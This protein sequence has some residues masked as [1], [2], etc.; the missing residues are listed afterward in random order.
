MLLYAVMGLD[1]NFYKNLFKSLSEQVKPRPGRPA[2]LGK[3]A[4][5][6]ELMKNLYEDASA[7]HIFVI[8]RTGKQIISYGDLGQIDITDL[9]ALVVGKM[10]ACQALTGL[11]D[12]GP[13]RSATIE[14]RQWGA[15]FSMLNSNTILMVIFDHQTNIDRVGQRVR[16]AAPVLSAALEELALIEGSS[17]LSGRDR[18]P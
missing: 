14:G 3:S 4:K 12:G 18:N 10:L 6:T 11:I 8:E 15:H 17:P 16:R 13:L 7:R 9:V 2:G 1:P 5:L